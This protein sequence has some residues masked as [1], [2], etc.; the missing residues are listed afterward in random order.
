MT[1]YVRPHPMPPHPES[2][3]QLLVYQEHCKGC[4][5]YPCLASSAATAYHCC[6]TCATTPGTHSQACNEQWEDLLTR[7]IDPANVEVINP[8]IARLKDNTSGI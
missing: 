4:D 5:R 6:V 3:T 7:V 1:R 2:T 8:H